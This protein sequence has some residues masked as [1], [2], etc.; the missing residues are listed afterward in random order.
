MEDYMH[1]T[2]SI[3]NLAE[4]ASNNRNNSVDVVFTSR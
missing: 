1:L 3:L 4:N 2:S